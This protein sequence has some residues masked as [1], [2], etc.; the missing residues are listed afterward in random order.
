MGLQAHTL[1]FLCFGQNQKKKEGERILVGHRGT[2]VDLLLT[3]APCDTPLKTSLPK[4]RTN[5]M[6]SGVNLPTFKG[7][8]TGVSE[9]EKIWG[10]VVPLDDRH[11][12]DW[13]PVTAQLS[14]QRAKRRCELPFEGS[15][16]MDDDL[17]FVFRLDGDA[18]LAGNWKRNPVDGLRYVQNEQQ[19]IDMFSLQRLCFSVWPLHTK[20]GVTISQTSKMNLGFW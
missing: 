9:F 7:Q 19:R 5:G 16:A 4:F 1:L 14:R 17:R 10:S 12:I 18:E 20:V 13:S 6:C 2:A 3:C 8:Q 15:E 11:A